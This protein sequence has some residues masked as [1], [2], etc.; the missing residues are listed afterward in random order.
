MFRVLFTGL[1]LSGFLISSHAQAVFRADETET[2]REVRMQWWKDAKFGMFVHWGIY[3]AAEGQWKGQ[4][5]PDMRP[6]IEWLMCKGAP[7]G[8]DVDEYVETLAPKMTLE[9]FRPEEWASL[10]AD[11]GMQYFVITAKHHDGFG[12]VDFP[13]TDYD[14]ADRTTYGKDPMLPLS[15][16]M[17][18]AGLRF[19]FYFSQS[20]DWSKPGGRPDWF[21]G[22]EGDWNEY[23]DQHAVPQLNH[24]LGGTYGP[25]DVLWF[26]SGSCTKTREGGL[27]IWEELAA[28]PQILVNNRLQVDKLGDFDCPEQWIP[29]VVQ[30]GRD[31]ETCMTLN[32]SWGYNPTDPHWK[33][34]EELIRNLCYVI[35]RGGNYL[36]NV[37]PRA[38]GSWEP[39]VGERLRDIGAWMRIN[40][41]S[42]YGTQPTELPPMRWGS[43]VWKPSREG[44]RL[45]CHIMEWPQDTKLRLPLKNKVLSARLMGDAD[46]KPT[47]TADEDGLVVDLNRANAV[48]SAATVL[49]L[50]LEGAAPEALN[51][52]LRQEYD[53]RISMKAPEAECEGGVYVNWRAPQLDGWHGKN[54][55]NR[56]ARWNVRAA[57]EDRRYRLVA[58]YG[59]NAEDMPEDMA[60]VCRIGDNDLRIPLRITGVEP[61]AHNK[62]NN[63]LIMAELESS[64]TIRLGRG[65]HVVELRAEGAPAVFRKPKGRKN[66]KLCYT[67]FPM[68]EELRLEPI[69]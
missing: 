31:W 32:G 64:D 63:Q 12:M 13:G 22:M 28:R 21:K 30:V 48:H 55:G 19:G 57:H 42:I 46:I 7:G 36:L 51:L 40:D 26:D 50:D 27:K 17:R 25:I 37:G 39:Q 23:V 52:V 2:Q 1:Y 44:C 53:G 24:L 6:G 69:D 45:Y 61:D 49:V 66:K 18:D 33:S 4:A 29:P 67:A 60:F 10:A 38:D 14:I 41:E 62:E 56:L 11:A 68:L 20:Q 8:I 9:N 58:R 5:F 34:S 3:A 35:S 54:R 47:W 59:F 15:K 43:T 65:V 16:A